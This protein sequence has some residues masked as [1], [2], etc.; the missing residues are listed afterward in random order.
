M[1][2]ARSLGNQ[3]SRESRE[4][5]GFSPLCLW[6]EKKMGDERQGILFRR[7]L[8]AVLVVAGFLLAYDT[9]TLPL[10]IKESWSIDL[11]REITCASSFLDRDHGPV[12]A[13]ATSQRP[14]S[15]WTDEIL[16]LDTEGNVIDQLAE[17]IP[18]MTSSL[19]CLPNKTMPSIILATPPSYM[20][21][22]SYTIKPET[23]IF[24]VDTDPG[25]THG[26]NPFSPTLI[27]TFSIGDARVLL[28]GSSPPGRPYLTCHIYH[29]HL[30][31]SWT[32]KLQSSQPFAH[33]MASQGS[34]RIL[35]ESDDLLVVFGLD[36][37]KL[38]SLNLSSLL[39]DQGAFPSRGVTPA[40]I[41]RTSV[42]LYDSVF[43]REK[44]GIYFRGYYK[45][46]GDAMEV[47]ESFFLVI[48][49]ELEVLDLWQEAPPSMSNPM[50]LSRE[51]RIATGDI[52]LTVEGMVAWVRRGSYA[53]LAADL[54]GDGLDEIV[55][56]RSRRSGRTIVSVFDSCGRQLARGSFPGMWGGVSA[57]DLDLGG[58]EEIIYYAGSSL[59]VLEID[60]S[61]DLARMLL[62]I[63][64]LLMAVAL[65]IDVARAS[66]P[67]SWPSALRRLGHALGLG[68]SARRRTGRGRGSD[69]GN[70]LV[71]RHE[72]YRVCECG[73]RS[74][75]EA[76]SCLE[77]GRAFRRRRGE[78]MD[79]S[80]RGWISRIGLAVGLGGLVIHATSPAVWS[81]ERSG[82]LFGIIRSLYA[83]I[84]PPIYPST[85]S[86]IALLLALVGLV[87]IY[88]ERQAVL[89]GVLCLL[90]LGVCAVGYLVPFWSGFSL[91][92]FLLVGAG[93]LLQFAQKT[94]STRDGV[95]DP[96]LRRLGGT[97]W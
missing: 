74:P 31:E 82:L 41:I 45:E 49:P 66:W 56:T 43:G 37:E 10:L 61:P 86:L 8:L 75:V 6:V 79:L 51:E 44:A 92:A 14:Y 29:D 7:L 34:P 90:S 77:C 52:C 17:N 84:Q 24:Q 70:G 22:S 96:S 39:I 65:L 54:L 35:A 68:P 58:R 72:E 36:G 42:R 50:F 27:D 73:A 85:A 63:G 88:L 60:A 4:G 26:E 59:R 15:G 89:G 97:N 91:Y 62:G 55:S 47:G 40:P 13:V 46:Q 16:L 53:S 18:T 12:L 5:W 80:A 57:A 11:G 64:L 25:G 83:A 93:G 71:V 21:G 20:A 87:L 19:I 48:G 9:A 32:Q 1:Y 2:P 94:I 38:Q 67:P 81:V 76:R 23:A 28:V 95:L 78:V 3:E 30:T 33:I 69:D